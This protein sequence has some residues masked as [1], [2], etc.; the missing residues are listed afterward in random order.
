[1]NKRWIFPALTRPIMRSLC[2]RLMRELIQAAGKS[3]GKW[4]SWSSI[5]ETKGL[6]TIESPFIS[7]ELMMYVNDFPEAVYETN[8]VET[9]FKILVIV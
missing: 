2:Y 8:K 7:I 5:K 1:M 9:P 4:A 6:I 3:S